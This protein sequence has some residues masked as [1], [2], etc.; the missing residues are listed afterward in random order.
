[1]PWKRL[2]DRFAVGHP[3]AGPT[4]ALTLVTLSGVDAAAREEIAFYADAEFDMLV[5]WAQAGRIVLAFAA[6]ERDELTL[7]CTENLPVMQ[8]AVGELPLVAAGLAIADLRYVIPLRIS[9]PA[10]TEH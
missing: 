10:S 8:A 6:I 9:A 5:S 1:M 3:P 2:S 7:L 4:A